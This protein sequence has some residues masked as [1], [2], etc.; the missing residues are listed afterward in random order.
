MLKI[1]TYNGPNGSHVTVEPTDDGEVYLSIEIHPEEVIG[2][3]HRPPAEVRAAVDRLL[4]QYH[5]DLV[6]T[7]GSPSANALALADEVRRLRTEIESIRGDVSR[8]LTNDEARSVAAALW[9]HAD[10][11]E[12]RR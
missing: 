8:A 6:V 4:E 11:N 3:R 9:H 7:T 5:D 2:H 1:P 10:E 12:R